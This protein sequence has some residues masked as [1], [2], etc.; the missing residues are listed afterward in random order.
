ME[1]VFSKNVKSILAMAEAASEELGADYIGSEHIL[2][3]IIRQNN[4]TACR[5]LK[6][7]GI[8]LKEVENRILNKARL[9]QKKRREESYFSARATRIVE[10]AFAIAANMDRPVIGTEHVLLGLLKE[11]K[12]IAARILIEEYKVEFETVLNELYGIRNVKLA[13]FPESAR[14]A[15]QLLSET[16]DKIRSSGI[17]ENLYINKLQEIE[18]LLNYISDQF[19]SIN[20]VDL[21]KKCESIKQELQKLL[22][23]D[24]EEVAP[25]LEIIRKPSVHR[26]EQAR[27]LAARDPEEIVSFVRETFEDFMISNVR[28]GEGYDVHKLVPE[29]RLILGGVQIEHETGLLG[30]SDADVLTH[31]VMNAILG[32]ANLGDIGRHFPDSDEKYR[33]VSSLH[34][35]DKVRRL[36]ERKKFKVI[37][38]D[39]TITAQEPVL[40]PYVE[41]MQNN[42]ADTL[43]IDPFRV[44]V[45][46]ATTE[47]LGFEGRKEGISSRCI[48][49]LLK[50]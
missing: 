23:R 13:G 38:L 37:N 31:A 8:D 39:C 32:A 35:L 18:C 36:M 3:G 17:K 50:H 28:I 22:S 24:V 9:K 41:Q 7:L 21:K 43:K 5:V 25:Q 49:L 33:D 11:G 44:N 26:V 15:R 42:L 30:H 48:C 19:E 20:Q 16:W 12:G 45:K 27:L 1:K 2:L 6:V 46:A 29:R 40:S 4:N 14:R 34:L 47:K 10:I